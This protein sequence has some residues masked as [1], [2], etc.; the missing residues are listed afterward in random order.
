M[1]VNIDSYKLN[2]AFVSKWYEKNKRDYSP[3]QAVSILSVSTMVPCIVIA[4]W[5]G[6]ITGWPQEILHTIE[7]L[8]K[9]YGYTEI[10][11]KP[12]GAPI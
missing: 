10:L 5:I 3:S 6:E 8:M 1:Q 2:K 4:Y 12:E 11:N 7:V 9:F